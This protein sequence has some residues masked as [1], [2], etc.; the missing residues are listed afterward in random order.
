[1]RKMA[2]AAVANKVFNSAMLGPPS[3]HCILGSF[4]D[5]NNTAQL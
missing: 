5:L 3:L 4:L 2:Q 1:M